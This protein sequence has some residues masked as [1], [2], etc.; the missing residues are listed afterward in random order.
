MKKTF[1]FR[2]YPTKNQEVALNRT[3]STCRHLYN[4]SLG[5]RKRQSE[6]NELERT[7]GVTPWGKPEWLN[8][9]DQA[10]S[11]SGS[12]TDFQKD[13]FSQ[14]LQN[15]LKRVERSFKNFFNGFGYPRFQGR[16]RYNSFTYPQKGFD[17]KDGKLNLS[18]IGNIRI[19]L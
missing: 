16:E 9:Y 19:I 7:F 14:V 4:D 18:K 5:E 3:L 11:L 2:I 6:L 10:N 15:V 1:Q 17:L 13:V 8:Y 12:K